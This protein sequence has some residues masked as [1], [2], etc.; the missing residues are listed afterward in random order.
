MG[1]KRV[2]SAEFLS[3]GSGKK[4]V[5]IIGTSEDE[6]PVLDIYAQGSLFIETDTSDAY[7]YD[8]DDGWTKVGG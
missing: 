5:V 4:H 6:K 3:D 2:I 1:K 8:E 7:W